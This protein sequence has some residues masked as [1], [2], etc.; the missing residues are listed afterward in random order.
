MKKGFL[1]AVLLLVMVC[2]GCGAEQSP[3]A[4]NDLAAEGGGTVKEQTADNEGGG[5]YREYALNRWRQPYAVSIKVPEKYLT[6]NSEEELFGTPE[7]YLDAEKVRENVFIALPDGCVDIT[8]YDGEH[9]IEL[10]IESLYGEEAQELRLYTP[11]E[12]YERYLVQDLYNDSYVCETTGKKEEDGRKWYFFLCEKG[13]E[14]LRRAVL[15]ID[16]EED[17]Y[18]LCTVTSRQDMEPE[19]L[20]KILDSLILSFE[21]DKRVYGILDDSVDYEEETQEEPIEPREVYAPLD[22]PDDDWRSAG[23]YLNGELVKLPLTW[24]EFSELGYDALYSSIGKPG[25][26]SYLAEEG[27]SLEPCFY[28]IEALYAYNEAEEGI[29]VYLVNVEGKT[30]AVK[31]CVVYKTRF[32]KPPTDVD[33]G[34]IGKTPQDVKLCNGVTWDTTYEEVLELMGEADKVAYVTSENGGFGGILIYYMEKENHDRYV[35]IEFC[36]NT[37]EAFAISALPIDGRWLADL[38]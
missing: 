1:A 21:P 27:Y 12:D 15:T 3:A 17:A 25:M 32:I 30:Q 7:E 38:P 14:S 2:T 5:G 11:P 16:M 23:F 37:V 26:E 13:E 34:G 33:A 19:K 6:E 4:G 22:Y 35:Q 28:S 31:D 29:G 10:N 24:D 18:L 36:E 8:L 9:E 20:E